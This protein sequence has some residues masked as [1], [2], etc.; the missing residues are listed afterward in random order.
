[1]CE[2]LSSARVWDCKQEKSVPLYCLYSNPTCYN[3]ICFNCLHSEELI[4]REFSHLA[5]NVHPIYYI[6]LNCLHS[7]VAGALKHHS[8]ILKLL[9]LL[10]LRDC[11]K[12]LDVVGMLKQG[13]E[14]SSSTRTRV[15]QCNA[16]VWECKGASSAR[17]QVMKGCEWE[18]KQ[19]V[20]STRVQAA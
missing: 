7:E 12:Y 5:V 18:S 14:N 2:S 16:W 4:Y 10:V 17:M 9:I 11:G 6:F 15:Q 13:C 20:R 19:S 1:M 3:P 8:I